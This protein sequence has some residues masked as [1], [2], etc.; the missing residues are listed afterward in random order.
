MTLTNPQRDVA[1]R[2]VFHRIAIGDRVLFIC[3]VD[4]ASPGQVEREL[5]YWN[6]LFPGA[7]E[8]DLADGGSDFVLMQ[9]VVAIADLHPDGVGVMPVHLVQLGF[10]AD[11]VARRFAE[12]KA[13]V[14]QQ[15]ERPAN[16]VQ[17]KRK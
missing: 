13:F 12:A 7:V 5:T 15:A 1:P 17:F 10:A 4:R 6:G 16:V 11:V 8:Y 14:T 2:D 9:M 3:H